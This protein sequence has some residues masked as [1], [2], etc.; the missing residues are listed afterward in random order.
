M[1]GDR[2]VTG[3]TWRWSDQ[4]RAARPRVWERRRL[5]LAQPR[6]SGEH[7]LLR[8]AHGLARKRRGSRLRAWRRLAL[9]GDRRRC[10]HTV[11]TAIGVGRGCARGCRPGFGG[12]FGMAVGCVIVSRFSAGGLRVVALDCSV[13]VLGRGRRGGL[14]GAPACR[15]EP[16]DHQHA[17]NDDS[18][19]HLAPYRP[20][21]TRTRRT[22]TPSADGQCDLSL[23]RAG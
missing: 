13:R 17:Q 7:R 16:A 10:I 4:K 23:D 9:C 18:K 14:A 20:G 3:R 12:R 21:H 15:Q 6:P 2:P 19:T 22:L 5:L 8:R 1:S 11:G